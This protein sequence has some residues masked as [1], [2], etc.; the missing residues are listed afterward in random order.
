M[1]LDPLF[2]DQ[3]ELSKKENGK[4]CKREQQLEI[5]IR[6]LQKR[7][8]NEKE[9]VRTLA[10]NRT[11]IKPLTF[12]IDYRVILQYIIAPTYGT[13]VQQHVVLCSFSKLC[14]CYEIIYNAFKCMFNTCNTVIN[15]QQV[16]KLQNIIASRA[17]QYNHSLKKKEREFSRLKEHLSQLLTDKKD[18]N[19]SME[20][21]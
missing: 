3:L 4:L 9:E 19:Q 13:F 7:L 5:N 16:Q 21:L 12:C 11:V 10:I 6:N 15:V 1:C 17:T 2:Q 14:S 18:M 8:K 20:N